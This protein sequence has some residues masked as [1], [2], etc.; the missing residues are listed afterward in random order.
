[1]V[2]I[3]DSRNKI[4]TIISK[5]VKVLFLNLLWLLTSIP[6]FTIGASTTAFYY[7]MNKTIYG[8][9][10]YVLQEFFSTFKREFKQTTIIWLCCLVSGYILI[11]DYQFMMAFAD[12]GKGNKAIAV[13][14]LILFLGI[15][16]WMLYIFPYIARFT[17]NTKRVLKNSLIMA[18]A[19]FT[20]TI[21]MAAVFAGILCLIYTSPMSIVFLPGAY[22]FI[23]VSVLEEIFRQSIIDKQV[24]KASTGNKE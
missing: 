4:F 24:Q 15:I 3:L 5:M 20:K 11:F 17:D 18:G 6:V 14:L 1:M 10:G 2:K 8:G 13:V 23:K 9:Q 12:V 16:L 22:M 19:N 7:T 21:G